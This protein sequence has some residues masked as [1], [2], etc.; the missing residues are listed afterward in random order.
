M[1]RPDK[2][3]Q[4]TIQVATSMCPPA[5]RCVVVHAVAH[6]RGE[7]IQAHHEVLP[8]LAIQATNRC[9]ERVAVK[10]SQP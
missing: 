4:A 6:E 5:V 9:R 1:A 3:H 10:P 8:V 7:G 2:D